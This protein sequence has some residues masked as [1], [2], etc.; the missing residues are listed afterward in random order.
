MKNGYYY[1]TV[2]MNLL[3]FKTINEMGY[4]E[5]VKKWILEEGYE[6]I[7][8]MNRDYKD[9]PPLDDKKRVCGTDLGQGGRGIVKVV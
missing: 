2:P 1:K 4:V 8:R 3:K 6:Q 5:P 7:K 9:L